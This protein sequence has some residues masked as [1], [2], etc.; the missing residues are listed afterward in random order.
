MFRRIVFVLIIASSIQLQVVGAEGSNAVENV[1]FMIP[2]GFSTSYATNYRIFK[3]E[4]LIFDPL[5][6]GMMKTNS[7]DSWV[8]DSAAAATAMSTG[9]KTNNRMIGVTAD[10]QEQKT[11]LEASKEAGKSTGLVTTVSITDATPAA[12]GAHVDSRKDE[13]EI[14]SQLITKVDV[15]L[16]GGKFHFRSE[17]SQHPEQATL[18]EVAKADGY[19]YVETRNQLLNKSSSAEKLLGLFAEVELTP[20]IDKR[21]NDQP[22]LAEMTTVAIQSL[23]KNDKGFFLMVEGGQIDRAGHVHDPV[24]AMN[25]AQA[26]EEAVEKVLDFAKENKET[27]V[28]IAGDHDTGGMSVGGYD[29]YIA[30]VEWL[31]EVKATGNYIASMLNKKRSNITEVMKEFT[32]I[33]ITKQEAS[34]IKKAKEEDVAIAINHIISKR[35]YIG[36]NT[37]VHSGAN[38]PIFAFGPSSNLFHGHLD[39]TDVPKQMAAAMGISFCDQ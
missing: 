10:G 5:L 20:V 11:I 7:A 29:E 36:W 9:M 30:N 4:E 28:V 33:T 22:S 18:L 21:T 37:H 12:F 3:G 8:T 39:N 14:A 19:R 26:F 24:W 13:S 23:N 35:A 1:I 31:R 6:V 34:H 16:G 38:V 2:D 32:G 25:E 15:L 27:L 17:S